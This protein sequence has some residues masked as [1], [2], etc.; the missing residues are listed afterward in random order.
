MDGKEGGGGVNDEE[1]RD[2][3]ANSQPRSTVVHTQDNNICRP[4]S[5]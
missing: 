5:D 3:V 2:V 1:V 4:A